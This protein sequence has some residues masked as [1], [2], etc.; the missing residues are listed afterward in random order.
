MPAISGGTLI[1]SLQAIG[2]EISALASDTQKLA[3]AIVTVKTAAT[4]G[5]VT[6]QHGISSGSDGHNQDISDALS[7]VPNGPSASGGRY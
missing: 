5:G 1:G 2:V 7:G 4:T 3:T 6:T